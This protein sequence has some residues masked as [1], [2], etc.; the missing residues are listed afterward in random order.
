VAEII[1]DVGIGTPL[2][3]EERQIVRANFIAKMQ[4]ITGR[5]GE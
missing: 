3:A 1:A 5:Q 4:E 2:S